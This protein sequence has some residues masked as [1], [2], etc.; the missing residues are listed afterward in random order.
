M[1]SL[2]GVE[3]GSVACEHAR[4]AAAATRPTRGSCR[5]T[6]A[7]RTIVA[8]EAGMPLGRGSGLGLATVFGI[9]ELSADDPRR[10]RELSAEEHVDVLQNP[11]TFAQLTAKMRDVVAAAY[12]RFEADGRAGKA[13]TS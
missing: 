10:A 7:R 2:L 4:I 6:T 1:L 5:R 13:R 9:V 8:D 12:R 3:P 11:F